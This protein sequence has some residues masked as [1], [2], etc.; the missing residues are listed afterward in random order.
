MSLLSLCREAIDQLSSVA[1]P[2]AIVGSTN[3]TAKMLLRLANEEGRSLMRRASWQALQSEKTF[4]T[5]AADVQAGALPDDFDRMVPETMFNRTRNRYV[6]GPISAVDWQRA[7]SSLVTTINPAYRMRGNAI[8][9]TPQQT[10]G[11]TIAFEYISKNWCASSIGTP[12]ASWLA[13]ND[14]GRLDESLMSLGIVWRFL[15]SKGFAY[16]DDL[17]AYERRVTEASMRDGGRA[18]LSSDADCV[19]RLP[20]RFNV[21]GDWHINP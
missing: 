20:T 9:F 6:A 11:E 7:K 8:L 4:I 18:R 17:Q 16:A 3:P 15:K 14:V 2:T 19:D 1:M 21:P 13:D 10:A 5:T 12:Q